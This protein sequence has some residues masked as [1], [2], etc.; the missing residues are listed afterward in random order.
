[1]KTSLG[2]LPR[3]LIQVLDGAGESASLTSPRRML[4]QVVHGKPLRLGPDL[5]VKPAFATY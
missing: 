5:G 2:S 4:M 3:L 1:M